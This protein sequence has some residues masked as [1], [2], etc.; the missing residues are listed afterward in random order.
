[1]LDPGC[2][3]LDPLCLLDA[4]HMLRPAEVTDR[5]QELRGRRSRRSRRLREVR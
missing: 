3:M 1:M 4:Y 2:W 5:T